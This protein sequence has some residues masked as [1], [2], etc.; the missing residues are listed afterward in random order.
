LNINLLLFHF[1]KIKAVKCY[2]EH[3]LDSSQQRHPHSKEFVSNNYFVVV[4][5]SGKLRELKD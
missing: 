4:V 1:L 2:G 5:V 3:V